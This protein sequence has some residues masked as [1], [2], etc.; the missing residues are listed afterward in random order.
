[1]GILDV[2]FT[3]VGLS[4]DAAAVGAANGLA[5]P[6]MRWRK[7]LLI[8]LFFGAAQGIMPILGYYAGAIFASFVSRVAPYVALALLGFIGGKM[9]VEGIADIVKRRRGKETAPP[10]PITLPNL[11]LQTVATSIDALAVG[12]SMLA[13]DRAGEMSVNV[14]VS[15]AVIA[16]CTFVI[17]LAAVL[18]G[19]KFGNFLAGKAGL[20]GGV[21]LVA[22]GLKIFLEGIL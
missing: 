21:I 17:S 7:A 4:M 2:I 15:C 1:M 3:G 22:I 19:R 14:F 8:A 5:E 9:I 10:K 13:L 20:V 12:I 18:L 6:K 11:C 16:A